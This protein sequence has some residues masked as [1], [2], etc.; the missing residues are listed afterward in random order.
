MPEYD[1]SADP[2]GLKGKTLY[3][4]IYEFGVHT[5]T[6]FPIKALQDLFGLD[7]YTFREAMDIFTNSHVFE[8]KDTNVVKVSPPNG[9]VRY[10]TVEDAKLIE[11]HQY[12][13]KSLKFRVSVLNIHET[14]P[15]YYITPLKIGNGLKTVLKS[16]FYNLQ[17]SRGDHKLLG[18]NTEQQGEAL[19][20][21]AMGSIMKKLNTRE[22]VADKLADVLMYEFSEVGCLNIYLADSE[23]EE[24]VFNGTNVASVYSHKYGWLKTNVIPTSEEAL[25]EIAN[26][27]VRVSRKEI[28]YS[29]P[30]VETRLESGERVNTILN[31]VSPQGTIVTI[32]KFSHNPW[33]IIGLIKNF[34]TL[35]MDIA[36][37]LWFGVEYDL[38]ILV[39]GGSGSG[40]TTLLNAISNL[41]PPSTHV[42]SIESVREIY[43]PESRAW[44]WLSLISKIDPN[45]EPIDTTDLMNVSLKMR[46][47][48]IILG[49]AVRAEEIRSLFQAMQVGHPVYSTIHATSSKELLRRI[50]DPT[51]AIPKTDINSLDMV[52]VMYNDIKSKTRKLVE[53][54]EVSYD[55][56]SK[57]TDIISNLYVFNPRSKAYTEVSKPDKIFKKVRS[58]TGMTDDEMW[59]DIEEKKKVLQWAMDNNLMEVKKLELIVQKYYSSRQAL[60][61]RIQKE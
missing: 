40:K 10:E 37:L 22:E 16:I 9:L 54:S 29:N 11:E 26:R 53:V 20:N 18:A 2:D 61:A 49:E 7:D 36:A 8:L 21:M 31:T 25:F 1:I 27:M 4:K 39:A 24:I 3:D 50:M 34:Q 38:N 48:R 47:E 51:Y 14:V 6:P 35:T 59:K 56:L 33:T 23:I 44:N 41:I 43:I 13:W 17:R 12:E 55:P 46:P 5:Q 45:V 28:N 60:M 15:L 32:R 42:V 30:I 19:K 57:E 58:K 52:L